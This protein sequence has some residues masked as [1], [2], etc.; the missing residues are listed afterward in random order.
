MHTFNDNQNRPWTLAVNI[1][2]IKR[3]RGLIEVDLLTVADGSLLKQLVEDP[4]F[5]CDVIYALVKPEAD[6]QG[7]TDEQ[8]GCA[9][10]G[11]A[12]EHATTALLP[13]LVGFFHGAK[14]RVLETALRRIQKLEQTA[15]EM[16]TQ[17]IEAVNI[18]PASFEEATSGSSSITSPA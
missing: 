12:I 9:M 3:V 8:F 1:H 11:D 13:E 6:A 14:R 5:L 10:A 4:V 17:Q 16:A 7:V 15:A 2:A 18:D